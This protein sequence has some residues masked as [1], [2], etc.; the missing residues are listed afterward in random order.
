MTLRSLN[1]ESIFSPCHGNFCSLMSYLTSPDNH[2]P[3][4]WELKMKPN[5]LT[6]ICLY[7]NCIQFTIPQTPCTVMLI[8]SFSH[9][10]VHILASDE[11]CRDKCPTIFQTILSGCQQAALNLSYTNSKPQP[12]FLCPCGKGEPHV[13]LA[14]DPYWTCSLNKGVGGRSTTCQQIWFDD[15]CTGEYSGS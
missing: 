1:I 11:V 8:D 9:F 14:G 4:S 12:A 10:E 13:T 7:R 5:S 2:L 6:P 15:E 3:C